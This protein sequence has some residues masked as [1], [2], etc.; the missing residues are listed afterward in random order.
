[1]SFRAQRSSRI[2]PWENTEP[3]RH[4]LLFSFVLIIVLDLSYLKAIDGHESGL[5]QDVSSTLQDHDSS[6]ETKGGI[7]AVNE[8][9][10]E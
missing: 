7:L 10:V 5:P 2:L 8:V 4:S 9:T 3:R 1:M 6:M